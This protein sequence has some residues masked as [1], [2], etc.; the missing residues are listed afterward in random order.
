M[1]DGQA[2]ATEDGGVTTSFA[3]VQGLCPACGKDSLF[4]GVGG[5]VTCSRLTCPEPAAADQ[6]LR[7][8]ALLKVTEDALRERN[9]RLGQIGR[10][11]RGEAA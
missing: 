4:L 7:N 8:S 3:F 2:A 10:L 11:A 6:M 5:H 1:R 9:Q